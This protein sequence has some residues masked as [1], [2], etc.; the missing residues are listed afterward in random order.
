MIRYDNLWQKEHSVSF[1]YQT[2]PENRD[3]VLAFAGSYVFPAPWYAEHLIA[4][5]GIWSN[6]NTA[7]G[8]GFETI[9]SGQMFGIRYVMP[10]PPKADYSHNLTVG[11]DYKNFDDTLGFQGGGDETKTPITY[12]PLMF[13]YSGALPDSSGRTQLSAGLNMA[14]R[15]VVTTPEEFENKRFKARGNYIY[16]TAGLERSQKLPA[17]FSLFA[18]LD[19]QIADQPLVSNEQYSAGGMKSVRGYKESAA[20]GDD[21]LHGT[22]ELIG[23]DLGRPLNLWDQLTI[24]PYVFY[25]AANLWIISPLPGQ[26]KTTRL[27]G[28][29]IGVRG[30]VTKYVDYE[31]VWGVALEPYPQNNV[32]KG[33]S[34]VYFTVKG[35]F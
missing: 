20:L 23:P 34:E 22:L 21:A 2:S 24:F 26:D 19:G 9:G 13:S 27:Q 12:A 3:E 28:V 30:M 31:L 8:E 32:E 11:L 35:Q 33:E 10:L 18:K 15:T 7:F 5:Y 17:D 25:D 6:G 1:Q 4:L 16:A 14:F 29:G